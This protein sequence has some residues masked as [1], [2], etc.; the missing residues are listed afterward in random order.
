MGLVVGTEGVK[1]YK[2]QALLHF[3]KLDLLHP[4]PK[5]E[6]AMVGGIT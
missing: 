1:K 4:D 2:V 3:L 6:Q 5:V